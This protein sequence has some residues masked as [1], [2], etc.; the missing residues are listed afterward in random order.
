MA[1]EKGKTWYGEIEATITDTIKENRKR[2]ITAV[3]LQGVLLDIVDLLKGKWLFG[4]VVQPPSQV[5][6]TGD[7]PTFYIAFTKGTYTNF[8]NNEVVDGEF[9]LFMPNLNGGWD[10]H[11]WGIGTLLDGKVNVKEGYDLSKND[12]TDE[13]RDKVASLPD[14][15]AGKSGDTFPEGNFASFDENGNM[16]DSGC[17]EGSFAP[18]SQAVPLPDP[19]QDEGKILSYEAPT[20]DADPVVGWVKKPQ[21]GITPHID[22]TTKEWM[23]GDEHTGVDAEGKDAYQVY[24]ASVPQGET[25]MTKPEWL[26]SLKGDKGADAVSPFKGSYSSRSALVGKY[27]TPSVGNYAYVEDNGTT[28]I[29]R[30][31]TDG[32]W[33]S[34][35]SEEKEPTNAAFASSEVLSAVRIDDTHLKNAVSDDD[36]NEPILPRASDVMQLADKL[37]GID[38]VSVK[39]NSSDVDGYIV[40]AA[41]TNAGKLYNLPSSYHAAYRKIDVEGYDRVRFLGVLQPSS[42]PGVAGPAFY[43]ETADPTTTSNTGF[44]EGFPYEVGTSSVTSEKEYVITVPSGAKYL[45]VMSKIVMDGIPTFSDDFYCFLEKGSHVASKHDVELETERAKSAEASLY[46][47][48]EKN[49]YDDVAT[50]L[51]G[52]TASENYPSG[53]QEK[54]NRIRVLVTVTKGQYVSVQMPIGGGCMLQVYETRGKAISGGAGGIENVIQDITGATKVS[55]IENVEITTNGILSISLSKTATSGIESRFTLEEYN[56]YL[57]ALILSVKTV[58]IK[59]LISMFSRQEN[60]NNKHLFIGTLVQR[61]VESTKLSDDVDD[62]RV[63]M[64]SEVCLPHQDIALNIKIKNGYYFGIRYGNSRDTLSEESGWLSDGAICHIPTGYLYYRC[65]FAK[66]SSKDDDVTVSEINELIDNGEIE[67]TYESNHNIIQANQE[68]E[69]YIKS[70]LRYFFSTEEAGGSYTN[71]LRLNTDIPNIPTFGHTSDIHGD[72]YRYSQFLDYCD[73][74]GVDAALISGD[75]ACNRPAHSC[76]YINDVADGHSTMVLP[77]TGNHDCY[78]LATAQEQREQVVGYLMDKNNVVTNPNEDYPTYFYKDITDK[79]IRIISLNT[80]EGERTAHRCNFTQEQCEWFIDALASTPAGFG[81]IVMFHSPE[82]KP[83][84]D[85]NHQE[86]YQDKYAY[87]LYYQQGISG[88]PISKIVDA[89]ISKT[90]ANISYKSNSVNITVSADFTSVN[91]GVEFIAYVTGHQHI[92]WIGLVSNVAN[93]QL[94]LNVTCCSVLETKQDPAGANSSDLVR[95]YVGPTQDAF[96]IYG[97]DRINKTVRIVRV[98][99]NINFLGNDRK[100]MIIPYQ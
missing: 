8:G 22:Q 26:A 4:G 30:C 49:T 95:D 66:G 56:L 88:Y 100:F 53:F 61:S 5:D 69:K 13:D 94:M 12:Y 85:N 73:Y 58:G 40:I 32:E 17:N 2:D 57:S 24:V 80:Y 10:V 20:E 71:A 63:S 37:Q 43:D 44:K 78:E 47:G 18:M 42:N 91:S 70:I 76:Q 54:K 48:F 55:S 21:D 7:V 11:R 34:T 3:K 28:Y 6:I 35:S 23:I 93:R 62:T 74:I 9:A 29:Y 83:Q 33:P 84:I 31:I 38:V 19:T 27:S 89:F 92:D 97:I 77:C 36:T 46:N 64:Q 67:I 16:V 60:T 75:F 14:S 1:Y 52:T 87:G 86:F 81:V 50:I 25:P 15:V 41:G 45:Y 99:S 39:D 96:N 65:S 51:A 59:N 82:S 79:Q 68:S 98:G 72:V 90:T